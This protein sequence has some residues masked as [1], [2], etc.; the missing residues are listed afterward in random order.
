MPGRGWMLLRMIPCTGRHPQGQRMNSGHTSC[1]CISSSPRC[2]C[3][4]TRR[5]LGNKE[6]HTSLCGRKTQSA[7]HHRAIASWMVWNDEKYLLRHQ[8]HWA[9]FLIWVRR[10]RGFFEVTPPI[11]DTCSLMPLGYVTSFSKG[12][13]SQYELPV[14][15]PLILACYQGMLNGHLRSR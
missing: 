12:P 14:I 6:G 9:Q 8:Y 2:Q 5:W 1:R 15:L 10:K 11:R 3:S 7:A 4:C 13:I